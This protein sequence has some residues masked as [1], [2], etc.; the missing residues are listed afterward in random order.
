MKVFGKVGNYKGKRVLVAVAV[1]ALFV[2]LFFSLNRGGFQFKM[3]ITGFGIYQGAENNSSQSNSSED[4]LE[5]SS[6]IPE[7]LNLSFQSSPNSTNQST[8]I[9][10]GG[11]GS[12]SSAPQ[13]EPQ[14]TVLNI[15]E[16]FSLFIDGSPV[17][18]GNLFEQGFHRFSLFASV[19]P[20]ASFDMGLFSDVDFSTILAD[21][22]PLEGKVFFHSSD[23]RFSNKS[24]YIPRLE[25]HTQVRLCSNAS[26]FGQIREHCSD[27]P[28]VTNEI[29]YTILDDDLDIVTI[30]GNE[31]F[32]LYD[33]SGSGAE[34]EADSSPPRILFSSEQKTFT[35]RENQTFLFDVRDESLIER[36]EL[37]LDG[38]SIVSDYSIRENGRYSF[39]YG[40]FSLGKHSVAVR[41][42]DEHSNWNVS[43]Q[44]IVRAYNLSG[45][46]GATSDLNYGNLADFDSLTFEKQRSG[47]I[48]FME[49][50]NLSEIFD[51]A[52]FVSIGR[53]KIRVNSSA[54]PALNVSAVITFFNISLQ[55]P[56]IF[57]DGMFCQDCRFW[58]NDDGDISFFVEHFS[59]YTISENS[60]LFIYDSTDHIRK[61][62]GEVISF[63]SNYT[64]TTNNELIVGAECRIF[65]SD[66]GE[67]VMEF[68][69]GLGVYEY[70]RTFSVPGAY[71][72]TVSCDGSQSGYALLNTTDGVS[73]ENPSGAPNGAKISSGVSSRA[74]A[75][76]AGNVSA[77]AGNATY[78]DIRGSSITQS[79]QGY[80]GNVSGTIELSDGGGNV[81]YNWS[82]ISPS[83]EVYATRAFDFNFASAQCANETHFSFEE[84][85]IG[86]NASDADSV[87][88]TFYQHNHPSFVVGK[89]SVAENECFST[90]AFS[91]SGQDPSHFYEILLG[92]SVLNVAYVSILEKDSLGFDNGVHD[93]EMIVGEDGHGSDNAVTPYYFFIELS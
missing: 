28:L 27:D 88:N 25:G 15:P 13:Q 71:L 16:K 63:Y 55:K 37:L 69:P 36:C 72:Y 83:G 61:F 26:D 19:M 51:L 14:F 53:D 89:I 46:D 43:E 24:L 33:V 78:L 30:N 87:S 34:S 92:D 17:N 54:A 81:F 31:Y 1:T 48:R 29:V 3:P 79:W 75:D 76:P 65:F 35:G 50:V 73:I 38:E 47:K 10:G 32:V 6:E 84:F 90:N 9:R 93:F 4:P 59:S 5:Y 21:T 67:H 2:L 52:S 74:L 66:S 11:G 85:A 40:Q 86:Q 8:R 18:S 42:Q 82:A 23:S 68:N 70:N 58:G 60:Q 62:P 80:Y 44:A 49:N 64:N 56:T 57:R 45:F 22:N 39:S 41:C 12:G 7:S 91:S 77:Q 20:I